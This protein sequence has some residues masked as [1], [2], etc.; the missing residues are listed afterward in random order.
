MKTTAYTDGE[1]KLLDYFDVEKGQC[2]VDLLSVCA[3]K[4]FLNPEDFSVKS[5]MA[6]R[7]ALKNVS[8]RVNP[9]LRPVYDRTIFNLL[10]SN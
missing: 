5:Q 3:L 8:M 6:V 7:F 1:N 10:W 4:A 9:R 2:A